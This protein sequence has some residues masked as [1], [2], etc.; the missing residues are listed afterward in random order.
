MYVYI[1]ICYKLNGMVLRPDLDNLD[2]SSGVSRY[3]VKTLPFPTSI[4]LNHPA[5]TMAVDCSSR[6][7]THI[8]D[9]KILVFLQTAKGFTMGDPMVGKVANPGLQCYTENIPS[10]NPTWRAGKSTIYG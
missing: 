8:W 5:E 2:M 4:R 10:S 7:F 3:R 6:G 9:Y 1:C